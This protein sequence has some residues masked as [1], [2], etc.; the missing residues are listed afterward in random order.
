MNIL[1][2]VLDIRVPQVMEIQN[3]HHH[4]GLD[5][6]FRH[7]L[8][9]NAHLGIVMVSFVIKY[10]SVMYIASLYLIITKF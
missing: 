9:A 5:R 8:S 7:P 6:S 4:C 3:A 2:L 1:C 10:N